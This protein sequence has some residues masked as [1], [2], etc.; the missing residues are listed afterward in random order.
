MNTAWLDMTPLPDLLHDEARSGPVGQRRPVYVDLLPPYDAG[1]PAGENIQA[2]PAPAQAGD[3][4]KAGGWRARR[5]PG[6]PTMVSRRPF[7]DQAERPSLSPL[8]QP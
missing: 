1:C 4:Q 7:G 6:L 3:Y 5:I 2:W 8:S